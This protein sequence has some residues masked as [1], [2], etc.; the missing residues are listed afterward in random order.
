VTA[1]NYAHSSWNIRYYDVAVDHIFLTQVSNL[2]PVCVDV[3]DLG[4]VEKAIQSLGPI[5][6]L[7]NNAGVTKLQS[8]LDVTPEAYD[9]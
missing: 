3:C 6:L 2:T 9:M 7:V 4:A 8:V 1:G 5:H